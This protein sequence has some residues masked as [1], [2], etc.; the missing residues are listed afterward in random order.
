VTTLA[1]YLALV[2]LFAALFALLDARAAV[3]QAGRWAQL[4]SELADHWRAI[5][6]RH[7]S[8]RMESVRLL[9]YFARDRGWIGDDDYRL[10]IEASHKARV[11]IC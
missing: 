9:A 6:E 7:F 2:G 10:T 3:A 8:Q 11:D 1:L 5:A 4:D